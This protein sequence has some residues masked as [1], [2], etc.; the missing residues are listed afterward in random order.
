MKR[1][2]T[3]FCIERDGDEFE[4]TIRGDVR[5]GKPA[6]TTGHMDNWEPEEFDNIDITEILLDNKVWLGKLSPSEEENA[7][8]YL[9]VQAESEC[10]VDYEAAMDAKFEAFRDR[11]LF[12]DED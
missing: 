10:E 6:V 9:Q 7:K 5:F 12:G 1:V 8:I 4:L 3:T 2:E 11:Q